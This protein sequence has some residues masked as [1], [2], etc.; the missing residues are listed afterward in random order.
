MFLEFGDQLIA[1]GSIHRAI[2]DR[3][4]SELTLFVGPHALEIRLSG[5]DAL[6]ARETLRTL[7]V[8]IASEGD[9]AL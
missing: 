3:S 9:E 5:E 6:E 8:R 4:E 1:V 2:W 7:R